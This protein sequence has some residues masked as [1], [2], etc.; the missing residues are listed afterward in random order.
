[1]L[2]KTAKPDK[3]K[4]VQ[5]ETRRPSR[6]EVIPVPT[7]SLSPPPVTTGTGGDSVDEI[8]R[9]IIHVSR[10]TIKISTS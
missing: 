5:I 6:F 4:Q 7:I 3:V 2:R 9:V 8:H 1:M 10:Y